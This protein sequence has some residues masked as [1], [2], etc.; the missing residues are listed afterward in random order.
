MANN[1]KPTGTISADPNP[2][3]VPAGTT[4]GLTK[5]SWT[6]TAKKVAVC[7][8]SPGGQVLAAANSGSNSALTGKGVTDR[9]VFYLQDISE[10]QQLTNAHTLAT[11]VVKHAPR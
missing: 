11:V 4:L 3:S 7:I 9:M 8:G 1:P 10:G 6:T 5:I 2:I